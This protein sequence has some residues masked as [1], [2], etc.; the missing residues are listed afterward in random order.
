MIWCHHEITERRFNGV[1]FWYCA[2][3]GAIHATQRPPLRCQHAHSIHCVL[4]DGTPVQQCL[5][6]GCVD[7]A[8]HLD[9]YPEWPPVSKEMARQYEMRA[10][11]NDKVLADE[12]IRIT[13]QFAKQMFNQLKEQAHG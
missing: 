8:T 13:V 12:Q 6:C 7:L 4:D 3:C 1:T 2:T 9:G 11:G 5:M 10:A